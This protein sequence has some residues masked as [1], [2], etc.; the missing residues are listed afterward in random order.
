MGGPVSRLPRPTGRTQK[1]TPDQKAAHR[2]LATGWAPAKHCF[3][4][5]K[6]RRI[7]IK[8]RTVPARGTRLQ[9]RLQV[10]GGSLTT[11]R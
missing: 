11:E 3:A 2:V 10:G 9:L 4:H 5:L 7:L 6:Y 1:L 8:L